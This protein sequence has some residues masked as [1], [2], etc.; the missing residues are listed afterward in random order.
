[1]NS[2]IDYR[3]VPL[4]GSIVCSTFGALSFVKMCHTV[5]WVTLDV[6]TVKLSNHCLKFGY[7]VIMI[8]VLY[9]CT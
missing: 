6:V 5:I 3:K 2:Y 1:M 9:T 4:L 7:S 8:F